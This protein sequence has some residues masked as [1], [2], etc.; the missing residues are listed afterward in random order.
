MEFLSTFTKE[1]CK[2]KYI[3][4]VIIYSSYFE[5]KI[6]RLLQSSFP[7]NAITIKDLTVLLK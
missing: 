1:K 3:Y 6:E 2:Y 4:F 7:N 5:N